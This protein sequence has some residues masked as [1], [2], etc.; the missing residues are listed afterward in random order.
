MRTKSYIGGTGCVYVVYIQRPPRHM[1]TSSICL[2]YYDGTSFVRLSWTILD[3]RH[4]NPNVKLCVDLAELLPN[5]D[6]YHRSV[7]KLNYL[8]IIHLDV[9]FGISVVSQYTLAR[10]EAVPN[11][12]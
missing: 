11:F 9:S 5:L 12:L 10:W 3:V 2:D 4:Y 7:G 1:V 6:S 8:T